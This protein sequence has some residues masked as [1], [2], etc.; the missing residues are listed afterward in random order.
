MLP[1]MWKGE[2][3]PTEDPRDQG[4]DDK[5]LGRGP[6]DFEMFA[7]WRG[8]EVDA[9]GNAAVVYEVAGGTV[10]E[11]FGA[12]LLSDDSEFRRNFT[13][14]GLTEKVAIANGEG[15]PPIVLGP[16]TGEPFEAIPRGGRHWGNQYVVEGEGERERDSIPLPLDNHADRPVRPTAIAF[17]DDGAA[18][19]TTVDG[20]VW[21]VSGLDNELDDVLWSR[22][23]AGLHEP[24]SAVVREGEL[25]VFD[26]GGLKRLHDRDGDGEADY[27]EWF[28][29]DFW[30][31]AETRD[32]PHDMA[33]RPDGGFY[34]VKG[35][36]QNDH[37][38]RH[39]GRVLS[40]SPDGSRVEVFSSGHRNAYLGLRGETGDLFACDQ[41]GHWVPTTPVQ[42]LRKGGYYGFQRAA[43]HGVPEPPV[44][45]AL[46]WIPHRIAQ[47]AVDVIPL[48]DGTLAVVDY[49]RPGLLKVYP[50]G[51]SV[52]AGEAWDFPLLKGA[53]N[54]MDGHLYVVGFQIWGTAAKELTGFGRWRF[55][56]TEG[57]ALPSSVHFGESGVVL[58]FETELNATVATD[59]GNYHAAAWGY[60][61]T[62]N[63]GS[64]HYRAD[65]SAGSD[66][67]AVAGV[68]ASQD[69]KSVFVHLPDLAPADQVELGFFG[70]RSV[71]FTPREL[72]PL[73]L[74]GLGFAPIDLQAEA[75]AG[76][77]SAAAAS[78][79]DAT[80]TVER[81]ATVSL[82][83]GCIAC[84]STDGSTEGK[85]GPTWRGLA[86]AER[87]FRKGDPTTAD[88]EYLREAILDPAQKI[89][90]GY[91]P[92]DVGMPS[93]RGILSDSDVASLVL[94]IESLV[95]GE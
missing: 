22:F 59:L 90:K 70:G 80:P 39:S 63:Y 29:H 1:G 51:A 35:G 41:Q 87:E 31:S 54:P 18:A 50:N 61:R 79:P 6:V 36:Q 75:A 48:P 8:V 56:D 76:R 95:A 23:A 32:F 64:G 3:A 12:R 4:P 74:E 71:Y 93:Y 49:F 47:S 16:G 57:D 7:R 25:F 69:G 24:Y 14:S 85:S 65:G 60:R 15:R 62:S 37:L 27:H 9:A 55:S 21:F 53:I 5:E 10:R 40:V 86:G 94:Y 84:H 44:E 43:P 83:Y 42:L 67:L 78:K 30:Q 52:R 81:G 20:D 91:D 46:G 68:H 17:F 11:R 34:L 72:A 73:D 58:A 19:I 88:A 26:R 77:A 92:K 13:F 2:K 66:P 28:C 89:V 33:L 82:T 45:P 38:S